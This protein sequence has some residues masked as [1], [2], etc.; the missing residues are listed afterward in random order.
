MKNMVD[1]RLVIGFFF[2]L[3][4]IMLLISAAVTRPTPG[5]SATVNLYCGILYGIFGLVML[6]IWKFRK[7]PEDNNNKGKD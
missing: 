7:M 6:A 2:L 3:A 5:K 1:L 4:G